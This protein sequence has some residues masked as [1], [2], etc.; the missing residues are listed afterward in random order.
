MSYEWRKGKV[1]LLLFTCAISVVDI[2]IDACCSALCT[3]PSPTQPTLCT[4]CC[5]SNPV[6]SVT[7]GI[8][9]ACLLARL[10]GRCSVS[11]TVGIVGVRFWSSPLLACYREK[12]T[13]SNSNTRVNFIYF[14][15]YQQHVKH[16]T[17][18]RCLHSEMYETQSCF[19]EACKIV[20]ST[21]R[22]VPL[23][24]CFYG[25][26]RWIYLICHP[27]NYQSNGSIAT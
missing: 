5:S 19:S 9:D 13:L 14:R 4:C 10:E 26:N 22:N 2:M 16:K 25:N 20:P 24:V 1:R 17:H 21:T 12:L 15:M 7:L 18:L 11:L 27:T 8:G 23:R 6:Q 3:W